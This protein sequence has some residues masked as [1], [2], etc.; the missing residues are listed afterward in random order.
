ML[1]GASRPW[2]APS[3]TRATGDFFVHTRYMSTTSFD[4][5]GLHADLMR[6]VQEL[7]FATPTPVQSD[8]IPPALAG[9]DVLACAT[10]GSGK[11]A[12]FLLPI[13]QRLRG[14]PRGGTRAL[15]LVPTRELAAQV[16]EHFKL[17]A[18]HT[19]LR[20]ASVYGGVGM[21]PQEH[22]FMKGVDVIVATPGRLLDHMQREYARMRSL[23]VLVLDEADRMLDMGFLPDIQ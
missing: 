15:V 13:I 7:E 9:R 21:R 2:H 18:K 10:T 19:R 14:T 5:L 20:V 22:A 16:T 11:T 4:T 1:P 3:E 23:E 12:A 8:A 17:L 6:A